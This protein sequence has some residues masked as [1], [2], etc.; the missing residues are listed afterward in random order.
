MKI[1]FDNPATVRME[2]QPGDEI[3]VAVVPPALAMALASARIDGEKV[4]RIVDDDDESIET[5]E[6]PL[7]PETAAI[8]RGRIRGHRTEAIRG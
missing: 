6:P 1:R 2:F 7:A 4:A 3:T 8:R 5:A